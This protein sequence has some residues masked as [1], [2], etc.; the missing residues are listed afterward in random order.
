MKTRKYLLV[1]FCIFTLSLVF[2]GCKTDTSNE[3]NG[4]TLSFINNYSEDVILVGIFDE[5]DYSSSSEKFKDFVQIDKSGGKKNFIVY[6]LHLVPDM[7]SPGMDTSEAIRIQIM[8]SYNSTT[9][10]TDIVEKDISKKNF[11]II[12]SSDDG[13]ISWN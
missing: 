10:Y 5:N 7:A 3:Q 12:L 9:V 8:V 4:V 11:N 1:L 2:N 6:N 13:S